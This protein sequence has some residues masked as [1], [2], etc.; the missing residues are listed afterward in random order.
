MSTIATTFKY[1]FVAE[2]DDGTTY[3]QS[4]DDHSINHDP[5]KE[6]NP[7]S[8]SDVDH[9]KLIRF[10]LIEPKEGE[11]IPICTVDLRDG[12]FEMYGTPFT[13]H[14]QF[15]E[16]KDLKLIY[17]RDVR[18][19]RTIKA[20]VQE[21]GTIAEEVSDNDYIAKYYIG[22]QAKGDAKLKAIVGIA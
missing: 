5:T 8:F 21:D 20:T 1:L 18:R 19:E 14:E 9:D 10:H 12:H 11:Q 3:I 4:P 2:Y 7:S 22:W 17:F 15:V 13:I 16:P 6:H